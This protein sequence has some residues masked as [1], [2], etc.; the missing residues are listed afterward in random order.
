VE[1]GWT[2]RATLP[3]NPCTLFLSECT[4]RA[5]ASCAV[6]HRTSQKF[7]RPL[8]RDLFAWEAKRAVAVEAFEEWRDNYHPVCAK[9][10]AKDLNLS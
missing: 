8:Y 7:V 9:M 5:R 3:A 4:C 10:L 6:V 1:Q 2:W